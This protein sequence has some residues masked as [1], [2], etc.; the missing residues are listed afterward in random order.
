M[1]CYHWD[2]H[3]YFFKEICDE[4]QLLSLIK[5]V[6]DCLDVRCNGWTG[7]EIGKIKLYFMFYFA[8]LYILLENSVSTENIL[9][10]LFE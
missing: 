2:G 8:C 4:R 3:Y 7:T 9:S 6:I 10:V 1:P 5:R